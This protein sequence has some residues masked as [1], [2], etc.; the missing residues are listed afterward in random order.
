[1]K[2]GQDIVY[3]NNT[4]IVEDNGLV[5]EEFE[6]GANATPAKMLPGNWVIYDTLEGDIK[7]AGAKAHGVIGL[8]MEKPE[9]ALTDPYAVGDQTRVITGGN[10]KV[11][12]RR[13]ASAGN[14]VPGT[15]L[16]AAADGQTTLQAVGGA[17]TQG[18]VVAVGAV[19][20]ADSTAIA[21]VVAQ[22]QKSNEPMA[23]T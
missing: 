15:A 23:A 9:G 10:G 2:M 1:M 17:G 5:I 20:L 13:A 8:L 22:I 14:I 7:E 4:V 19:I 16:V 18:D 11:L 21:N 6:V 12:V 3:P